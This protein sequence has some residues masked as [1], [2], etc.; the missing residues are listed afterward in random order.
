MV[1]TRRRSS[2][3]PMCS[4]M[5]S[6][7][8][9]CASI[10]LAMT[11]FVILAVSYGHAA[12][13]TEGQPAPV[14]SLEDTEGRPHDL[15]KAQGLLLVLYFCDLDSKPNLEGLLRLNRLSSAYP[16]SQLQ[17]WAVT[18]SSRE[19]AQHTWSRLN[20]TFPILPDTRGVS[21]LYDAQVILPM[22]YVVDG[23]G[24]IIGSLSG[25]GKTIEEQ[26]KR[27]VEARIESPQKRRDQDF[28]DLKRNGI[29]AYDEKR[30]EPASQYLTKALAI[31]HDRECYLYL[32]HAWIEMEQD[33]KAEQTLEA[34]IEAYPR[35]ARFFETYVDLYLARK[36]PQRA[37]K[38]LERGLKQFPDDRNLLALKDGVDKA[39]R[40]D[41]QQSR[42]LP[43]SPIKKT[44]ET[45]EQKAR[46]LFFLARQENQKLTWDSCLA[47]K[48][49]QRAQT[50]VRK[51]T[52]DHKDPATGKNPAW[53]L[54]KTC[55]K[56]AFA[57]EN[58][59][60]GDA[61][62]SRSIHAAF[63]ESSSHRKNI[64]DTHFTLMG[65]GCSENICVELFAG[66]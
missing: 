24:T 6:I 20:L 50:M 62:S 11:A 25:T 17:V 28:E 49:Q 57:G 53:D 38:T 54:V 31:K 56:A 52:F 58:L 41:S 30:L 4:P 36:D 48:A 39:M 55:H 12:R 8:R 26:L 43:V 46:S 23:S 63:M 65:V 16:Q 3:Q 19:R 1:S 7:S 60:K 47:K 14:F 37:R 59:S 27:L 15:S 9:F 21:E 66:F 42:T 29:Q 40:R 51:G 45:P 35:E 32:A 61:Q 22:L 44:V 10:F 33:A 2:L 34:A 64:L 13:L 18:L 5:N